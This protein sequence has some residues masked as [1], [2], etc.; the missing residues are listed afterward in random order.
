MSTSVLQHPVPAH[1][2]DALPAREVVVKV[3]DLHIDYHE[4]QVL[5]GVNLEVRRG[6]SLVIIG[7]SGCGKSTLLRAMIGALPPARGSIELF[8]TDIYQAAEDELYALRKRFGVL[9]Q[10]GALFNSMT[11]GENIALLLRE[12]TNLDEEIIR[13]IVKMKLELV[14]LRDFEALM[15]AQISGGMKKRV[16]LARALTLD[17]EI[18]FYDEPSAGLDPLVERVIDKLI[19]DLTRKLGVSSI[20]VTHHMSSAFRIADQ[21]LLLHEGEV[22][23][24][25]TLEE[26]RRTEDPLVRQFVSGSLEGPIPLYRSRVDYMEDLLA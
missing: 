2:S 8:G 5:R 15:P 3:R 23:A 4:R 18:I 12:H 16:G 22:A 25:G 10:S 24:A 9:F 7:A 13:I 6:E 11:V 1:R 20:V 26:F 14:G 19:V 17:P 21:M